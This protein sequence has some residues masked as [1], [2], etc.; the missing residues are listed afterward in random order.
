MQNKESDYRQEKFESK[1]SGLLIGAHMHMSLPTKDVCNRAIRFV[2]KVEEFPKV[3]L[4]GDG[5]IMMEW[6]LKHDT[7]LL[8]LY[9]GGDILSLLRSG[10]WIEPVTPEKLSETL[11]F[12][13]VK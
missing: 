5:S 9:E 4:P 10:N 2:R 11:K 8:R 1:L 13:K 12:K 3:I 7:L 6:E